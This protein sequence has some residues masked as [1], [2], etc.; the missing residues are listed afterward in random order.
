MRNIERHE[1][2]GTLPVSFYDAAASAAVQ[3]AFRLKAKTIIV[4]TEDG[5][6]ARTVAKCTSFSSSSSTHPPTHP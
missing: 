2:S 6:M 3:A 1:T 5:T 4:H